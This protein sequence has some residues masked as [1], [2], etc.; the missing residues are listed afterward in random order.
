[1]RILA[2]PI[3]TTPT[4][5]APVNSTAPTPT[6]TAA[7]TQM[8]MVKSAATS[9]PVMVYNLVTGKFSK[10]HH[11][12]ARPQNK[13]HPCIQSFNPP[14]LEDISNVP[15]RQGTPWPSIWSALENLLKQG[16]IGQFSLH[17]H[18]L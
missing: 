13:G 14:L 10:V 12:T 1:M 9:I 5:T 4:L 15:V 18:P 8:H 6:V 3:P 11:P 2:Q 16:K 17:L 7:S